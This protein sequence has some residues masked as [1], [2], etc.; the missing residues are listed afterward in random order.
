MKAYKDMSKD[1][2]LSLKAALEDQYKEEEAKG[3]SL[4]MARG[5][6]GLSQL[7][8]AMPMLD[9][10]NSSSDM[11]TVLGNDTRN[12]GDLD[13]I[14]E[15]RRLMAAMM[16]VEKDNVIVCGNSSLNIMYDTVSRSMTFG[17]NGSTPWCKLDKVK[18]LC[19][20]PGYDR[21]FKIT[22][23]FGIE[24]INIPLGS[25]GPDMDLVEK[26]VNNDASVKGIWCVPKY[27]NPTGISYSDEVV[28]RFANLKPA[29]E[30]FRIYWDN[31]YSVH[32]LYPDNQD[33]LLEIL[34]ECAKAGNPDIVYKFTSTSK[35]SF[36][37]SGIAALA[38]SKDNIASIKKQLSF[39]T[40]GFDKVNQL[41]HVK[42]FKNLDGI[43]KQMARHAEIL[44]PK[45]ELVE[46]ILEEELK[47]LDIATWTKPHGGYFI[48][49]DTL[50]NCAKCVISMCKDAGVILT[51]A[52][53]T[54]PYHK[55]PND[56]NIRIAPSY[57]VLSEIETASKILAISIKICSIEKYLNL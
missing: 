39:Q 13:G 31:A 18:F 15:C 2:L 43:K 23:V 25:D 27:S 49:L 16:G 22:E 54:Y 21:H 30:D 44:R 57:P 50:P 17:V 24:M 20:V 3:L 7:A 51:P 14:G 4:N 26:Y 47:G 5:K 8:I 19:P 35:I 52:G 28:K 32:H 48:S 38:A 42:F 12:Y 33:F 9:V 41:R 46:A 34:D 55:D 36:P 6:P 56:S 40:I 37:G 29:A 1:E 10:I 53:S 45:F 11:N